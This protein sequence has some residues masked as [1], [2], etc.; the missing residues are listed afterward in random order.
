VIN[1]KFI[2]QLVKFL[3]VGGLCTV[4][5]YTV[6][7]LN[8]S[9]IQINYVVASGIGYITGLILGYYLN[10]NWT[11]ATE[12]SHNQKR[13]EF[14]IYITV[15]LISLVLSLLLVALLV[16][17]LRF[18]PL[19]ANV[20]AIGLSTITNFIGLKL[21]VFIEHHDHSHKN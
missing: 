5:N 10:R 16:D 3:V 18:N 21:V 9:V 8:Y 12:K 11:F 1:K 14:V 7:Y 4:L 19:L 6:F 15:Y 13:R 17:V 2:N 20:F